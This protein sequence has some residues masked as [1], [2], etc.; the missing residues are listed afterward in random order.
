MKT[1][2]VLL[3]VLAAAAHAQSPGAFTTTG[4]MITPR[5]SHTATLL[6]NG[7]VLI[8]GGAAS[9]E[10]YD[11]ATGTFTPTGSMTTAYLT[12]GAVLLPDGKVLIGGA[13]IT[14]TMASVELYDPSTGKF[15]TAGK[16]A[17]LTG[18]SFATLLNDG[19]VL[20]SGSV[21]TSPPF[22]PAAELYDPAAGT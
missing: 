7:M 19:R 17:T 5:F 2:F 9:A 13:D 16:P 12:G 1:S 21:R 10:L 3:L 22:V 6:H 8:A 14:H 11:P 15:N 20:L 18:V 4:N